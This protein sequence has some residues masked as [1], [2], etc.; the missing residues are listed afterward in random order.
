MMQSGREIG[1]HLPRGTVLR[2]G[3]RLMTAEGEVVAVVAAPE[4]VSAVYCDERLQLARVA[5]L[6]CN[7]HVALQ[8]GDGWVRY[9]RDH[10]LD[11]MVRHMGFQVVHETQPFEPESG[12][13]A[14]GHAHDH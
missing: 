10:V 3:D 4:P 1:V 8:V 6:L 12:A 11:D 7:R 9:G 13:Y 5:Y 2:G 14:G